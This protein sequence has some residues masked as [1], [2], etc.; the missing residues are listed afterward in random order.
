M[1]SEG[2]GIC[3]T[4]YM[5]GVQHLSGHSFANSFPSPSEELIGYAVATKSVDRIKVWVVQA[6]VRKEFLEAKV[7]TV[8]TY[9]DN[10]ELRTL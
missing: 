3:G 10:H 2:I 5:Y 4:K 9:Y 1:S 6:L 7:Y 8:I